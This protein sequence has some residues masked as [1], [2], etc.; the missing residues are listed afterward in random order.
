MLII[1]MTTKKKAIARPLSLQKLRR[2][3]DSPTSIRCKT[4]FGVQAALGQPT[5][6]TTILA[7]RSTLAQI[8]TVLL[9]ALATNK[10]AMAIFPK[11]KTIAQPIRII[12]P[13][14]RR[15]VTREHEQQAE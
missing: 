12:S 14:Q 15:G 11:D 9:A 8:P 10:S 2:L 1:P 5:I 7:I 6:T 13:M 4:G 3:L